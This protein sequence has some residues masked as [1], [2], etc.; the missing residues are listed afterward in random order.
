[1]RRFILNRKT[2]QTGV[3]GTGNVLEGVIL[4][5]GKVVAEWRSPHKTMGIYD[6]INQFKTIHVDCH[7]DMNEIIFYDNQ[8]EW[9]CF[10]CGAGG[11]EGNFCS[12]CGSPSTAFHPAY[13]DFVENE[14]HTLEKEL[15]II[16]RRMF[17]SVPVI[18]QKRR[19]EIVSRLNWGKQIT[20]PLAVSRS[21]FNDNS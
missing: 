17:D 20:E 6:S 9:H 21:S 1:M 18:E 7:P 5:S 16:N 8:K 19:N 14:R 2:D 15:D 11:M 13:E 12:L 10:G 3:S 4:A